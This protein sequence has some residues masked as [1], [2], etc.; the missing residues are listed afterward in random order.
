MKDQILVLMKRR[1][2]GPI[3][4]EELWSILEAMTKGK[5]PRLEGVIVEFFLCMWSI[6]SKEYMKMIQNS[7]MNGNFPL[8]VTKGLITLLHKGGKKKQ[9]SN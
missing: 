4:E 3:I 6:I 9:L 1:L 7:I 8:G 5:A 2:V